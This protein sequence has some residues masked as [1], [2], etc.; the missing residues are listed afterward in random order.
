MFFKKEKKRLIHPYKQKNMT[1]EENPTNDERT[2]FQSRIEKAH[3]AHIVDGMC[4][5]VDRTASPNGNQIYHFYNDGE[6]THQKG[7]W[8]YQRRT[9]FPHLGPLIQDKEKANTL[10]RFP[11]FAPTGYTYAVLTQEECESFR[12]EMVRLLSSM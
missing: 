8:A 10:F 11:I 3:H 6:I 2:T 5:L 1:E 4:T 7:G 9:E 12:T